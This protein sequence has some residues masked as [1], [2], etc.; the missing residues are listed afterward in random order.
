MFFFLH[1]LLQVPSDF[2]KTNQSIPIIP[3]VPFH[4]SL[5]VSYI[6]QCME[7]VSN[8]T[9]PTTDNHIPTNQDMDHNI[10]GL[11]T[12]YSATTTNLSSFGFFKDFRQG[13]VPLSKESPPLPRVSIA[14]SNP[15]L[16]KSCHNL[17]SF[18]QD[19][20]HT[21]LPPAQFLNVQNH[22]SIDNLIDLDDP[23][24]KS[25]NVMRKLNTKV[26]FSDTV[27]AFIVPEVKRPVKPPLPSHITDP[28]RE[29]AESLPLCHPN[30]DYLK[31]FAPVKK[32]GENESSEPSAPPKIK[33]VHF[34]VV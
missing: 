21:L 12:Q 19:L 15:K 17:D 7:N 26:K 4:R 22:V 16:S 27:T 5:G 28:Q 10:P 31:D 32:D 11:P 20:N 18:C 33:V 13:Y 34:G 14:S 3:P 2:K 1:F 24:P 25:T 29:L 9:K 23:V 30:E 6:Q 8:R